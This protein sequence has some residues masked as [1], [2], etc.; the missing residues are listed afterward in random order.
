MTWLIIKYCITAAIVVLVSEVAARSGKV[1]ALI[2]ALPLISVLTLIWMHVDKQPT[3]KIA[4]F[5]TYTLWYVLPTLPF[6]VV[7]PPLLQRFGFWMA[8]AAS[9]VLT[10]TTMAIA[11][12]ILRRFGVTFV[13]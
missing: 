7:F 8:L 13:S 3:E 1:G 5:T 2:A 6:F 11:A 12:M 10:M 4:T 9:L